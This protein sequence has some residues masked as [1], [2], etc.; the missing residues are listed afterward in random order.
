MWRWSAR[1]EQLLHRREARDGARGERPDRAG[2]DR[3]HPNPFWPRSH[4]RY[5]H[6]RVERR[7]ADAHHVAAHGPHAEVG[8][9]HDRAAPRVSIS[10]S[11]RREHATS[12][13]ALMSTAS[14]KVP[15]RVR[16]TALGVRRRREGDRV[17]EQVEAAAEGIPSPRRRGRGPRP[18]GRRIRSRPGA[19]PSR[20]GRA[21]TSR[22][23]RPGTNASCAPPTQAA[24][25]SPTRW[26]ACS[27]RRSTSACFPRISWHSA[28]RL[29]SRRCA[30]SRTT[31]SPTRCRPGTVSRSA[32]TGW[33]AR[34]PPASRTWT[35][36]RPTP[37][38][39][40]PPPDAYGGLGGA[41]ARRSARA[42]R[43]LGLGLPWSPE[44][45]ERARRATGATIL[46][47]RVA[48]EDGVAA[49]LGGGTH[50][51]FADVGRG[52]C[53]FNDVV[54]ALR[55]MRPSDGSTG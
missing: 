53:V 47:A 9:R 22:S 16:E 46:A 25:R 55:V 54:T 32:S 50:H 51:A 41:R 29:R 15:R 40:R 37:R 26:S 5:S 6:R 11:A 21:P 1:V 28:I 48:L 18:S 3:V 33:C 52:F 8:H 35:S 30:R 17:D 10:G 13:Y 39:G 2:G 4:A 24:R 14:Q 31:S 38:V 23:A 45:V 43:Q 44:L 20:R 12:E 36:T 49:N 27:R 7:L 19:R 42:A 34:R